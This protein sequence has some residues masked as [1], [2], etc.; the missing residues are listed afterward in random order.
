MKESKKTNKQTEKRSIIR[1]LL[2]SQ[3]TVHSEANTTPECL[4]RQQTAG[5]VE[6]VLKQLYD[7]H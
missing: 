1:K 7:K 5:L 6:P 4:S 3:G 2:A